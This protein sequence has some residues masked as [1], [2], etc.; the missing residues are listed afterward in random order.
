MRLI[1]ILTPSSSSSTLQSIPALLLYNTAIQEAKEA[2]AQLKKVERERDSALS[3]LRSSVISPAKKTN[4]YKGREER[5]RDEQ[6]KRIKRGTSADDER[7]EEQEEEQSGKKNGRVKMEVRDD[8]DDAMMLAAAETDE[9]GSPIKPL[10]TSQTLRIPG[11]SRESLR[12]PSFWMKL[13]GCCCCFTDIGSI[14]RLQ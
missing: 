3:K 14:F 11:Q 7:R 13:D 5:E 8:E 10:T 6:A 1:P 12:C 9:G 2:T 4:T